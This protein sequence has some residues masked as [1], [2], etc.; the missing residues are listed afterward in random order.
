MKRAIGAFLALIA[1]L[2]SA[3]NAV[4]DEPLVGMWRASGKSVVSIIELFLQGD[5][6]FGRLVK[7]LDGDGNEINPVCEKCR[8]KDKGKPIKGMT[9]I[10]DLRKDGTKWVDG[11]V[12]DIRPGWTQGFEAS[13]EIS[14][15]KKNA[16]IYGYRFFRFFGKSS[17]WLPF[18]EHNSA[19][20]R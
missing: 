12:T 10:R 13:C 1:L 5:R 15:V 16:V 4:A 19:T 3:T 9:F 7:T 11:R 14:L 8:G 20:L 17:T 2:C 6:L 18:N